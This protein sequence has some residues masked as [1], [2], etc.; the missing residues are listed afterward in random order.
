MSTHQTLA[1]QQPGCA[2]CTKHK[3][4]TARL[5]EALAVATRQIGDL[6]ETKLL[7]VRQVKEQADE[8][9]SPNKHIEHYYKDW[10]E[11]EMEMKKLR[12]LMHKEFDEAGYP[13][14]QSIHD[15]RL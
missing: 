9:E 12:G 10:G 15:S 5:T 7:L 1:P 2:N 14:K 11:K 3:E 8:L 6:E 13:S 4:Q